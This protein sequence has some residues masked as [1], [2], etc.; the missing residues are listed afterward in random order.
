M[1]VDAARVCL[2]TECACNLYNDVECKLHHRCE[3]I[4]CEQLLQLG[5]LGATYITFYFACVFMS[6]LRELQN[7]LT[8]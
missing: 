1:Y 3:R 8:L 2:L 7:A 4:V 6:T 5:L